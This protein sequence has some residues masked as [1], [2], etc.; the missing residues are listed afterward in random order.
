[1]SYF[2]KKNY[3]FR[4]YKEGDTIEDDSLQLFMLQPRQKRAQIIVSKKPCES[5][6][7]FAVC[8]RTKLGITFDFR[9]LEVRDDVKAKR[10]I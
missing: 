9:T 1:M 3:I 7:K 5:C 6:E 8:I 2:I 10:S 4:N